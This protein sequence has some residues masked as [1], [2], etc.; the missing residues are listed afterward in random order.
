MP[1]AAGSA[2]G[3]EGWIS[4]VNPFAHEQRGSAD[5]GRSQDRDGTA[6]FATRITVNQAAVGS[7][8]G[9]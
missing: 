4:V 2:N 6:I 1:F 5:T 7:T 8:L 9:R 3:S